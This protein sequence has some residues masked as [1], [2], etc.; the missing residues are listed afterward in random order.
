MSAHVKSTTSVEF[1]S[2]E[3][4]KPTNDLEFPS[5]THFRYMSGPRG[6]L[7][8]ALVEKG[9]LTPYGKITPEYA[10]MTL[11]P[12]TAEE[13]ALIRAELEKEFEI[14]IDDTHAMRT[15]T[16][17]ILETFF[18]TVPNHRPDLYA[19]STR[20]IGGYVSYLLFSQTDYAR[21]V[22]EKVEISD[23][24][25]EGLLRK[26]DKGPAD[27]DLR[28]HMEK[29]PA[30]GTGMTKHDMEQLRN[31]ATSRIAD[32]FAGLQND[33][34]LPAEALQ[35]KL[36]EQAF[37]DLCTIETDFLLMQLL[38]LK[39]TPIDWI[40]FHRLLRDCVFTVDDLYLELQDPTAPESHRGQPLES[41]LH[42]LLGFT[43]AENITSIDDKGWFRYLSWVTKGN[44]CIYIPKSPED[45]H[46]E[47]Y[48][49]SRVTELDNYVKWI[50]KH[51]PDD[52]LAVSV[53]T[54]NMCLHLR[55]RVSEETIREILQAELSDDYPLL[56]LVK[57]L[58]CEDSIPFKSVENVLKLAAFQV[59][60][61]NGLVEI[62]THA[63]TSPVLLLKMGTYTIQLDMKIHDA[64]NNISPELAE[65]FLL[66]CPPSDS[67]TPYDR[68]F[69][70]DVG[71]DLEKL[72]HCSLNMMESEHPFI[73]YLGLTLLF[74][75]PSVDLSTKRK[76]AEKNV[77]SIL[78]L[79][80]DKEAVRKELIHF[81]GP[82][83]IP[84]LNDPRFMEKWIRVL[85]EP[86][87]CSEET[88]FDVWKGLASNPDSFVLIET[89]THNQP[90]WA[91]RLFMHMMKLKEYPNEAFQCV[92]ACGN[93]L[94]KSDSL[95]H[96]Q[97]ADYMQ[98]KIPELIDHE[99][100]ERPH[101][102]KALDWY[103]ERSQSLLIARLG[104]ERGYFKAQ[105]NACTR[106]V[107]F[108][109]P[110]VKHFKEVIADG[111]LSNKEQL[112][113]ILKLYNEN[114][115][116]YDEDLFTL[117]LKLCGG[118]PQKKAV[119]EIIL[120]TLNTHAVKDIK[121]VE[122]ALKTLREF[123]PCSR[124]LCM[125]CFE[126]QIT[127][128][129]SM[130]GPW[131]KTL[132]AWCQD[133]KADYE[134]IAI[135]FREGERQGFDGNQNA[136]EVKLILV[137]KEICPV[138]DFI[139]YLPEQFDPF[140]FLTTDRVLALC[141]KLPQEER[142]LWLTGTAFF[143]GIRQRERLQ[144]VLA[145]VL[146]DGGTPEQLCRL[147]YH[148]VTDLDGISI[149]VWYEMIKRFKEEN[150]PFI[151]ELYHL[152][153]NNQFIQ[154]RHPAYFSLYLA[155]LH[156]D[157]TL[158]NF[159]D[160]H[161]I[162]CALSMYPQLIL[163]AHRDFLAYAA[164]HAPYSESLRE[165]YLIAKVLLKTIDE[166]EVKDSI[167]FKIDCY[168]FRTLL[169]TEPESLA[170]AHLNEMLEK[171]HSVN[172][173]QQA[174]IL[175]NFLATMRS[176]LLFKCLEVVEFVPNSTLETKNIVPFLLEQ[177]CYTGAAKLMNTALCADKWKPDAAL[178]SY[179]YQTLDG[180]L[181]TE[182]TNEAT[183][184]LMLVHGYSDSFKAF[185]GEHFTFEHLEMI[186][187]IGSLYTDSNSIPHL[188]QQVKF[189]IHLLPK[190]YQNERYVEAT[191]QGI[192]TLSR[193]A[194]E[195]FSELVH[196]YM[197]TIFMKTKETKKMKH[198]L[199]LSEE[200]C[201]TFKCRLAD[202]MIDALTPDH[203][204]PKELKAEIEKCLAFFRRVFP[205]KMRGTL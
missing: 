30:M 1:R 198:K 73:R 39:N 8:R 121:A 53:F 62:G 187:R 140:S 14:K 136:I 52:P 17:K 40:L 157:P 54:L 107:L 202:A 36:H 127:L 68:A 120:S 58:V 200:D 150:S 42:Y 24:Y 75:N 18:S 88:G 179:I 12:L 93:T 181:M 161:K 112:E 205:T 130:S 13:F 188:I 117:L 9:I 165:I 3:T 171:T 70:E 103:F 116:F 186:L 199:I 129:K 145:D 67:H 56:V 154:K 48:L 74:R 4:S 119:V 80:K 115:E 109:E 85:F 159:P 10:N 81:I 201:F 190:G 163:Y 71:V 6:E 126:K 101:S 177:E 193:I 57:K 87:R 158:S 191:I 204:Y 185:A 35:T 61:R 152:I 15:S 92:L 134:M 44:C 143:E 111:L 46:L 144:C 114:R 31:L 94:S 146:A 128:P 20:L 21:R 32:M 23:L 90:H 78:E 72:T 104:L 38:S 47:P 153:K 147:L 132:K 7:F 95:E 43:D 124:A 19:R 64:L 189:G 110:S 168:F 51:H 183:N 125:T 50:K 164:E 142:L 170:E 184:L 79:V 96:A 28:I 69:L 106:L 175:I 26:S 194:P 162:V 160:E 108:S 98:S 77:L 89:L 41:F 113:F 172:Y 45:P 91:L 63:F 105:R 166:Q 100:H 97:L 167:A 123:I 99:Q 86:E 182:K 180:L 34:F 155:A 203:P 102:T 174:G 55:G 22:F 83:S 59:Y 49:F 66:V 118:A 11:P 122:H 82:K 135:L 139:P 148:Y 37:D 176:P 178:W 197:D 169:K 76:L 29:H 84:G 16:H 25:D 173:W 196:I 2:V 133:E 27:I 137:E 5:L 156:A 60:G 141:E 192:I 151:V 65:L 195:H 131:Y 149:K 33:S 138:E